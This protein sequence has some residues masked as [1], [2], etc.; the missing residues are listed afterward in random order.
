MKHE[1]EDKEEQKTEAMNYFHAFT[2]VMDHE[3][4]IRFRKRF[5]KRG[6]AH[7]VEL[8]NDVI[9]RREEAEKAEHKK[10]KHQ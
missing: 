9:E 3:Q 8:M 6:W 10:K 7:M 4:L 5:Q 1:N 2:E